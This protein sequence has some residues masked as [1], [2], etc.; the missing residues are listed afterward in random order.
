MII[1]LCCHLGIMRYNLDSAWVSK[2]KEHWKKSVNQKILFDISM[3]KFVGVVKLSMV[4][5]T[6][7]NS[8]IPDNPV[9]KI[10]VSVW[11]R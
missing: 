2:E 11:D 8:L 10:D 9:F 7:N 3:W 1:C 6:T 5:H 4:V